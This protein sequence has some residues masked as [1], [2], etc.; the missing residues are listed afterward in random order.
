MPRITLSLALAT[1][2]VLSVACA[3]PGG[4]SP[5][6][7]LAVQPVVQQSAWSRDWWLPRHSEKIEEAKRRDIDVVFIGDSITHGWENEGAETWQAFY[8][9]R[10]ALNLGFSG[11]RTEHVLWR[12]QNGALDDIAPSLIV[13][14]KS[15]V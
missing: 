1:A 2:L 4:V 5:Q 9:E 14:R 7:S 11:D 12:L 3:D 8:G 10:N 13:D 15:V 6:T